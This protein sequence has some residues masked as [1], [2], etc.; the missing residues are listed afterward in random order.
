MFNESEKVAED[1]DKLT[2]SEIGFAITGFAEWSSFGEILSTPVAFLTF[3]LEIRLDT[4]DSSIGLK[5]S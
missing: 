1:N 4:K 2:R 5:M 3:I